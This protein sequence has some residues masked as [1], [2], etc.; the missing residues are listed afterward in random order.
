MRQPTAMEA[1]RRN[2]VTKRAEV[3]LSQAALADRADVSR[4]LVSKLEQ[5]TGNITVASLEKIAI[6]LG[7]TIEQLFAPRCIRVDDAELERRANSPDG[8]FV[9]AR[10]LLAAIDEAN[11]ARYSNAGRRRTVAGRSS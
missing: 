9:D 2:V 1:L 6:V 8:E 4:A 7:C 11:E 3:C 5:G 10:Q